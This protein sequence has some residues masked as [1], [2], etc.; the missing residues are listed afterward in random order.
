MDRNIKTADTKFWLFFINP[1]KIM[2]IIS[3]CCLRKF[4]LLIL[5]L[6]YWI[7]V[8]GFINLWLIRLLNL[9]VDLK[10]SNNSLIFLRRISHLT[11]LKERRQSIWKW[12]QR[13]V[14]FINRRWIIS[15]QLI[16][17]HDLVM[18]ILNLYLCLI[19]TK[20]LK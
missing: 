14:F 20:L 6:K 13:L 7:V 16:I 19:I 2:V 17:E 15:I 10:W 3:L 5:V 4:D 8:F 1:I 18:L 9:I 11:L 12:I